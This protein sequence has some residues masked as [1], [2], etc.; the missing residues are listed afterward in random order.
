MALKAAPAKPAK[1]LPVVEEEQKALGTDNVTT[2]IPALYTIWNLGFLFGYRGDLAKA[3]G[4]CSKALVGYEK[5]VGPDHPTS[6]RW[7]NHLCALDT[8]RENNASAWLKVG[9]LCIIGV[10]F[11]TVPFSLL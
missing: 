4:M 3:R 6:R 10:L 9:F 2:Y 7:R 8:V 1:K 11:Y 5:V